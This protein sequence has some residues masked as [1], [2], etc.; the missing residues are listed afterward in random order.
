MDS[1]HRLISGP[2]ILCCSSTDE[3]FRQFPQ[4]REA[5]VLCALMPE[6]HSSCE[7]GAHLGREAAEV[8]G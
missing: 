3:V 2:P 8:H 6:H 7:A 1:L 4:H 5:L